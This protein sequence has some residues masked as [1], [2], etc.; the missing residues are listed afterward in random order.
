MID[1]IFDK[2]PIFDGY[3][4]N[5]IVYT[6]MIYASEK[7]VIEGNHFYK[8][9]ES[10][11]PN[12]LFVLNNRN[13]GHWLNSRANHGRIGHGYPRFLRMNQSALGDLN[14]DLVLKFWTE[15]KTTFEAEVRAHFKN[16]LNF[17]EIDITDPLAPN[18][19]S[20]FTGLQLDISKWAHL[21]KGIID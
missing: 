3:S 2:K 13:T 4:E 17:L 7:E 21:N 12:S 6:D 1:N 11:Y 20:E 16:S 15:L 9:M 19:I 5:T 18:L 8:K 10:D 14:E